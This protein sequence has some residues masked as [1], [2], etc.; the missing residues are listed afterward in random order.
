[1]ICQPFNF[2]NS[3]TFFSWTTRLMD[4]SAHEKKKMLDMNVAFSGQ[5]SQKIP[6]LILSS[7]P[8]S[9]GIQT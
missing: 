8:L 3:Y 6:T 4:Y 1:M 7:L 9:G 5:K 2:T